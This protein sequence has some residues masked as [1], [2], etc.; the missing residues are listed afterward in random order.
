MTG[1]VWLVV[2][3]ASQH[4]S[5]APTPLSEL[6]EKTTWARPA[7]PSGVV[8]TDDEYLTSDTQCLVEAP[9]KYWT[10][11]GGDMGAR[12][13]SLDGE[14]G[15]ERLVEA[16]EGAYL[17][18]TRTRPA[19]GN[20]LVAL[21]R[22]RI[23]LLPVAR[24]DGLTVYAY[25]RDGSVFVVARAV[26]TESLG[27]V[28]SDARSYKFANVDC[29]IASTQMRL[30]NGSSEPMQIEGVIPSSRRNYLVDASVSKTSRDPEPLLSVVVRVVKPP[31][32]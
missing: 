32:Q 13:A 6:P 19:P 2:L 26:P 28:R 18:R 29:A 31:S 14:I 12:S 27:F 1:H 24:V 3:V 30:R 22:G 25:R 5:A 11:G 8:D 4:A 17:E 7:I 20:K 10:S 21:E 23:A 9:P 16:G 15:I